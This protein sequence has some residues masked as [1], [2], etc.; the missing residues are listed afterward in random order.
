MRTNKPS[1]TKEDDRKRWM[2]RKTS[3]RE[4]QHSKKTGHEAELITDNR[5][6]RRVSEQEAKSY[7]NQT[8]RARLRKTIE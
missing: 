5:T 7:M 1:K 8:D 3:K 6:R 2:G 4:P